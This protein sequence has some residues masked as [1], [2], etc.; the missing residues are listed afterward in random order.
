M[1]FALVTSLRMISGVREW[2]GERVTTET[3]R[4]TLTGRRYLFSSQSYPGIGPRIVV[5]HVLT[6]NQALKLEDL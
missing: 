4:E 3:W 6:V 2:Q 5:T 1:I